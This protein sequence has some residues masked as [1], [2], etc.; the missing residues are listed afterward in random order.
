VYAVHLALA[1]PGGG[2][3]HPPLGE[4]AAREMDVRHEMA[5]EKTNTAIAAELSMS[6]PAVE[7]HANAIQLRLSEEKLFTVG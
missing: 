3:K 1:R 6:E 2:G 5:Q 4:L 7:K